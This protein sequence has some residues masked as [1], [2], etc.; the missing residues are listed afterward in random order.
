MKGRK[1]RAWLWALAAAVIVA[2]AIGG[3]LA[4]RKSSGTASPTPASSGGDV[5]SLAG[6][7]PVTGQRVDLDAYQGKPVV[8][9]IWASWC[10]G[11]R[12][13]ARD[14]ASFVRAHSEAQVVGLDTQDTDGDARAFY[15]RFGWSHP[16]IRDRSGAKAAELALQGLPTT[17]FLDAEHREVT[18]IIGATNRAGFEQGLRA[19]KAST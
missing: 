5:V 18:R 17:L 14:L 9:N 3:V 2:A 1:A 4:A 10:T 13:E 12:T 8:L 16:S 11:C 19:A 7:S 6:T 15:R